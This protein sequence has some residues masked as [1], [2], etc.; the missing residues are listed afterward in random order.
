MSKKFVHNL[1]QF[2]PIVAPL[3]ILQTGGVFGTEISEPGVAL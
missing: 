2:L 3:A 1:L